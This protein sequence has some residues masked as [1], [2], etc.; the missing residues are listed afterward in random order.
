MI[1]DTYEHP[2]APGHKL[3]IVTLAKGETHEWYNYL[4]YGPGHVIIQEHPIG[5]DRWTEYEL[6]QRC[7]L[8]ALNN[9]HS[10]GWVLT[11]SHEQH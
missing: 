4:S 11:G 1:I 2:K 7:F 6:N 5:E 3:T 8:E 9:L 10:G